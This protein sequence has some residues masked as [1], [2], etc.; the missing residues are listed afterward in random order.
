M[1]YDCIRIAKKILNI[2]KLDN[3]LVD[4]LIEVQKMCEETGG[5]LRSRQVVAC[6]IQNWK[7]KNGR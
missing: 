5:S 6:I 7:N 3:S 1:E 4:M 2:D